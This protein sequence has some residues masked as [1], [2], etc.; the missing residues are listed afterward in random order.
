MTHRITLTV[1]GIQRTLH[2]EAAD[3][4]LRVLREEL[5]LTGAKK[6]CGEGECGACTILMNNQAIRACLVLAV[7]ADGADIVTIEGLA[8]PG[9]ITRVQKAFIEADAVQCGFC[10]P[11]FVMALEGEM[12]RNPHATRDDLL[13]ALGGHLCRCTGYDSILQATDTLARQLAQKTKKTKK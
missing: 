11:G 5:H 2:V 12:R 4:L 10:T 1:N 9:E 8:P 3:T 13:N 6:G 7:E